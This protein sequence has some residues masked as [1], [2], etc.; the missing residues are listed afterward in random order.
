MK[1]IIAYIVLALVAVLTGIGTGWGFGLWEYS[2]DK[3]K[4]FQNQWARI[5]SS[6]VS[7]QLSLL[8]SKDVQLKELKQ[9]APVIHDFVIKNI[10]TSDLEI[11]LEDQSS[12]V[13]VILPDGQ[14]VLP[15]RTFPVTLKLR[16]T[17]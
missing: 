13:E 15:G 7:P 10:G 16:N 4:F 6:N 17:S 11:K 8:G 1:S 2:D 3:E 9:G 12:N 14:V 5:D